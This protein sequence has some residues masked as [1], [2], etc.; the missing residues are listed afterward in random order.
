[1]KHLLMRGPRSR[2]TARDLPPPASPSKRPHGILAKRRKPS[3]ETTVPVL[4]ISRLLYTLFRAVI[5]IQRMVREWALV[6]SVRPAAKFVIIRLPGL[7]VLDD[8]RL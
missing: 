8:G 3:Q 1:M 7:P 6:R 4:F 5:C 2:A